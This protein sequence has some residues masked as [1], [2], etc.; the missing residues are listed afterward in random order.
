MPEDTAL[1]V[2][3]KG[4]RTAPAHP[5][6]GATTLGGHH[7]TGA[8]G[9]GVN[10]LAAAEFSNMFPTP[11]SHEHPMQSPC[12]QMEGSVDMAMTDLS[13]AVVQLNGVKSEPGMTGHNGC[14]P[15]Y[16]DD[17]TSTATKVYN[18]NNNNINNNNMFQ[19]G[20]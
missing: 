11:P 20:F 4:Q 18:N 9:G 7:L 12:G 6:P 3:G 2:M 14:S 17:D 8:A 5:S 10:I 1:V 16:H 15:G 13:S 19:I